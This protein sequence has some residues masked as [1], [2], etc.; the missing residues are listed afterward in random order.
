VTALLMPGEWAD[1]AA[2]A[3]RNDVQWWPPET[4][5]GHNPGT[6]WAVDAL[7]ICRTCPVRDECLA[8]ALD[9]DEH[10]IWGGTTEAERR[11]MK[12]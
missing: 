2:C 1:Q 3:G 11:A 10:G 6:S 9:A 5:R 12:P 4:D 7:R 8:H